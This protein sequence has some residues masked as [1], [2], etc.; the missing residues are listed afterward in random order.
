LQEVFQLNGNTD[1]S[2]LLKKIEKVCS[3]I[4]AP[5]VI[6]EV[7][8][9]IS[10]SVAKKLYNVGVKIIDVAGAGSISWSAIESNRSKDVVIHNASKAFLNWG[11][12]TAECIKAIS[13]STKGLKIIAS[14]AVKNGVD[15]AKS[16]SL[17]AD[18]CGNASDF[19]QKISISRSECENFIESLIM[20]LKTTMFCVGCQNIQELKSV[21]LIEVR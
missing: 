14:G 6:K 16:I 18:I 5:V 7:G 8:Y 12:Q 21:K 9:G 11:N 15:I 3:S 19:L 13:Q 20:E 10:A 4:Y 1:F 17:G 2:N